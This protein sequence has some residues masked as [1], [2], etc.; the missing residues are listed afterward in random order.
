M[1]PL[2]SCSK[3]RQSK[4]IDSVNCSTR[5]SVWLPNRPPHA[6]LPTQYLPRA[7]P[8]CANYF[9]SIQPDLKQSDGTCQLRRTPDE[10]RTPDRSRKDRR[11]YPGI[12]TLALNPGKIPVDHLDKEICHG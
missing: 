4:E 1:E 5:R 2:M 12:L 11:F 3:S 9:G 8:S 10:G 7:C 6:L